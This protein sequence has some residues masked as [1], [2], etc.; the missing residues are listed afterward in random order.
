MYYE[1]LPMQQGF[2]TTLFAYNAPP[3]PFK[4]P[5]KIQP[6]SALDLT[7]TQI[8][9]NMDW[10]TQCLSMISDW[11]FHQV[12]KAA[13]TFAQEHMPI[14]NLQNSTKHSRHQGQD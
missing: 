13:W 4:I 14:K 10:T 8:I 2:A 9:L 3:H 12:E 5:F 7:R 1:T 6:A 11:L